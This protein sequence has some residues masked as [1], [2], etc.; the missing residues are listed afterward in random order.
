MLFHTRHSFIRRAF[1]LS[2][3]LALFAAIFFATAFTQNMSMHY[4]IGNIA[5][6]LGLSGLWLIAYQWMN[7]YQARNLHPSLL[8]EAVAVSKASGV[9]CV[10]FAAAGLFFQIPLLTPLFFAVFLPCATLLDLALRRITLY[11]LRH[12]NPVGRE[13]RN[14]VIVGTGEAA[15]AYA[16]MLKE[17]QALGYRLLGFPLDDEISEAKTEAARYLGKL[18]DFPALLEKRVIDEVV[19]IM[20][21]HSGR[22]EINKVI[23]PAYAMGT[24]VRLPVDQFFD[25]IIL[26]K[27]YRIHTETMPASMR[28]NGLD[29]AW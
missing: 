7:L 1:V 15:L 16:E 12:V 22:E 23:E 27:Q 5:D 13:V 3:L 14:L 26:H 17:N 9:A 28:V 24:S 18:S 20:P 21:I 29:V 6:F 11:S 19:I 4:S 10:I 8:L 2:D 25:G